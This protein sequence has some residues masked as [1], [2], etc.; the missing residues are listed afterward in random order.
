MQIEANQ[1]RIGTLVQDAAQLSDSVA[2]AK[3]QYATLKTEYDTLTGS[4]ATLEQQQREA[5]KELA[6][7]NYRHVEQEF[8]DTLIQLKVHRWSCGF[9]WIAQV[10][11]GSVT[12]LTD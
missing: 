4:R 5:Q 10:H 8:R 11:F 2:A 12:A 6:S 7:P 1:A 3:R 9:V